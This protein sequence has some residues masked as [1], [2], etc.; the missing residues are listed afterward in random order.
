ME[1]FACIGIER[2]ASYLPLIRQR[3]GLSGDA[4]L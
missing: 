4:E 1:G 2:E 3:L